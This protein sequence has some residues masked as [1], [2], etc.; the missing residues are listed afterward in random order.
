MHD[1][2]SESLVD[3]T[4][5]ITDLTHQLD[6]GIAITQENSDMLVP[7][8]AESPA[9]IP[10]E[11]DAKKLAIYCNFHEKIG[12]LPLPTLHMDPAKTLIHGTAQLEDFL[13]SGCAYKVAGVEL[14]YHDIDASID[15]INQV[16]HCRRVIVYSIELTDSIV[17]LIQD[18]D[19]PNFTFI[20]HGKLN[21]D[22][23]NATLRYYYA[24]MGTTFH[25]FTSGWMIP[26]DH[27]Q[28]KTN[29]F[30]TKPMYFDVLYGRPRK[31][32]N[33][34][35]DYL[36]EFRSTNYFLE[37]DFFP[38]YLSGNDH[39]NYDAKLFWEEDMVVT[40]DYTCTYMGVPM[41][42]SQVMPY[43]VYQT[44]A[45]SLICETWFSNHYSFFSE[46]IAKPI[47]AK[48]L[49]IVISGQH[50]LKNLR[51]LGFRTFDGIIDESY[52][53]EPDSE[54]R[55]SMALAQAVELC[56]RDQSEVLKAIAEVVLHNYAMMK[57]FIG[58]PAIIEK[59]FDLEAIKSDCY[60]H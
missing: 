41:N 16:K 15:I 2:L 26:K 5:L 40:G 7:V 11:A 31:H 39:Y 24:H 51:S 45:Y 4:Q 32:R 29:P 3:L 37:S 47:V 21:F 33:F 8:I 17:Q 22:L 14:D 12:N 42:I 28:R 59:E 52:D 44:T 10:A 58:P 50:Y 48:R 27:T 49:F 53:A 25:F 38:E 30:V 46:K 23:S 55:W 35:Y 56:K 19:L 54:K 57:S 34:V 13:N 60:L 18:F 9:S 6:A 1:D 36:S 20:I 43:K